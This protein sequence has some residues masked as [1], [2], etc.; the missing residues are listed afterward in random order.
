[1]VDNHY[2][3]PIDL[4]TMQPEVT[5]YTLRQHATHTPVG[6]H[7]CGGMKS[8]ASV[9]LFA[10]CQRGFWDHV[11]MILCYNAIRHAM[12]MFNVRSKP[13]QQQL[14]LSNIKKLPLKLGNY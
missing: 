10:H 11:P 14:I 9:P 7:R 2:Y 1:M 5:S 8:G 4:F 3:M 6:R 12:P 13:H